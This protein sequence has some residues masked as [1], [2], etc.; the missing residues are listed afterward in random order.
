MALCVQGVVQ[1]LLNGC[2][3]VV[4]AGLGVGGE[5]ADSACTQFPFTFTSSILLEPNQP[6]LGM[7]R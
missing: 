5:P 7:V 1:P 6:L 2:G 3:G 4:T